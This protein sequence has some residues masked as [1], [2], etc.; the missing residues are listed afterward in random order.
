MSCI[1][2]FASACCQESYCDD[3]V[4]VSVPGSQGI[5][6]PPGE[7]SSELAGW[8]IRD[9]LADARLVP[10]DPGNR[11]LIMLGGA[12]KSDGFGAFMY[13]DNDSLATDNYS[14]TGGSVITPN[15]SSGPGRW[16]RM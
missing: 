3:V 1:L 15:D 10:S 7:S 13:W 6:G 9:T 14:T 5:P 12:T 16:L 4:T 2:P 11:F 8:F